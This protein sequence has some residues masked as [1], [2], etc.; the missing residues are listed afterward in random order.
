[1]RAL[2]L[3]EAGHSL[4]GERLWADETRHETLIVGLDVP[5][6]QLDR[7]IEERAH[8]MFVAGVTSEVRRALERPLSGTARKIIGLR[9]IAELAPDE[10]EVAI[11]A[12]TRRLAAYQRKWMRRI[13]GLVTVR[14]DRSPE[15]VADDILALAS[16]GQRIPAGRAG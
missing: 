3:A 9:E 12:R 2:E 4:R 10:A 13:P 14:A 1:M 6:S 15:E 8:A 5:A 11:A 7:R 16:G